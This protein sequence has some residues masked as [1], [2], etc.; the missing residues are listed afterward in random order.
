M[1][2]AL[3][4]GGATCDGFD[5]SDTLCVRGS[6]HRV[7]DKLMLQGG[8][9]TNQNGTGGRSIYGP[10]FPDENFNEKHREIGTVSMVP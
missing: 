5:D 9:I 4:I 8:D 7:V 10:T 6:I 2:W 1:R 3:D